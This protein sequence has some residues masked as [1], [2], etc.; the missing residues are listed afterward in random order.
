MTSNEIKQHLYVAMQEK[1]EYDKAFEIIKV[2]NKS[3]EI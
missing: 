2:F 3:C 1:N